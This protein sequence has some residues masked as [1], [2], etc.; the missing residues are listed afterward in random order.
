[1][2]DLNFGLRGRRRQDA[3]RR[4]SGPDHVSSSDPNGEN[5]GATVR[6]RRKLNDAVY[7]LDLSLLPPSLIA[8]DR[9]FFKPARFHR[10][11]PAGITQADRLADTL[12]VMEPGGDNQHFSNEARALLESF[13]FREHLRNLLAAP[14]KRLA[15]CFISFHMSR[16]SAHLSA[17]PLPAW[18]AHSIN[19]SSNP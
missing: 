1:L 3:R 2:A 16:T 9:T 12:I 8:S 10:S 14:S 4:L 17:I 11:G 5:A 15:L 6:Q 19:S 13:N 18:L 7:V